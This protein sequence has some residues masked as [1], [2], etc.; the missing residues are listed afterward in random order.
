MTTQIEGPRRNDGRI[1][2]GLIVIVVGLAML[3]DR[4]GFDGLH[5]SGRYWPLILI[6]LGLVKLAG[7]PG[8]DGRRG[9]L[10]PG[11][12]LV[13]VGFWGLVSEFHAFG[14][15]Y[16]NSWPLLVIGAGLGIVWRAFEKP[17]GCGPVRE[18]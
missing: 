17:A 7:A 6:A 3:A 5:L 4:T 1:V 8:P 15:N 13:F 14:L 2:G 12:W 9:S 10:R 16:G 18:N 11:A